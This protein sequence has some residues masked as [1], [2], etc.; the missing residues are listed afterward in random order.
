MQM[1]NQEEVSVCSLYPGQPGVTSLI[2]IY[3]NNVYTWLSLG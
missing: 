2:G 3:V 1:E